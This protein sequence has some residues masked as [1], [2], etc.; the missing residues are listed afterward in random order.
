MEDYR[1]R[2]AKL[3]PEAREKL[4]HRLR[5]MN[6][7]R[8]RDGDRVSVVN[9]DDRPAPAQERVWFL[10]QLEP[11]TPLYNIP[12]GLRLRGRLDVDALERALQ[13]CVARHDALRTN[14]VSVEGMPRVV[15][16]ADM[17]VTLRREDV[18]TTLPAQR[19]K[20]G[21]ECIERVAREPFDLADG[22]PFRAVLVRLAADDHMFLVSVHHSAFDGWSMGIFFADLSSFYRSALGEQD[23]SLSVVPES[24]R[25]YAA[26]EYER[27]ANHNWDRQLAFWRNQLDHELPILELPT[28]RPR[29]AEHSITGAHEHVTVPD[30]TVEQLR[31]LGRDEGCTLFMVTAAIFAVFLCRYGG[32]DE[33]VIGVPVAGRNSGA[34]E[35][36][37]GFFV[38]DLPLRLDMSGELTFRE[39]V[40]RVRDVTLEAYDNQDLPFDRLVAELQPERQ[41]ARTPFFQVMLAFQ[42]TDRTLP[43]LPGISVETIRVSTGTTKFELSTSVVEVSGGLEWRVEY[44]TQL[45]DP[46]T[47]QR[48]LRDLAA[49]IDHCVDAPDASVHDIFICP[50]DEIEKVVTI[51]NDTD[52]SYPR[53]TRIE[54]FVEACAAATP[55]AV[56]LIY[57]SQTVSYGELDETANRVAASLTKLGVSVRDIVAVAMPRSAEMVGVFIGILKAGCAYMPVDVEYP[58]ERIGL[59]MQAAQTPV[60][61]VA[62]SHIERFKQWGQTLLVAEEA[63]C[64]DGA[65]YTAESLAGVRADDVAAVLFTSGSTGEPKGVCIPHRAIVRLVTN[66]NYVDIC[67]DDVI[68]HA[69]NVSFDAH[70]FEIWGAL[71]NGARV[72]E[73]KR[74]V[75]LSPDVFACAMAEYGITILFLTT[76]LFN[77]LMAEVPSAFS[78]LGCLLFGGE[79]CDPDIVRRAVVDG[80]PKR[81]LH[82]YGPTESTTFTTWHEVHEVPLQAHTVPIGRA[83]SNTRVYVLD[84]RQHPVPVGVHG[85]LYIGGDGLATQYLGDAAM[86]AERFVP[87]PFSAA[88]RLYRTGDVVKWNADGELIF[89]GRVDGQ[90]KIRGFR[91]EPGEVETCLRQHPRVEN[92]AV[93]LH[94]TTADTKHLVAHVVLKDGHMDGA[95]DLRLYAQSRIP[96]YMVPAHIILHSQLPLTRTGKVDRAALAATIPAVASQTERLMLPRDD[97]E[98]RIASIWEDVLGQR[99][100]SVTDSFFD[101]G[102]HSLLAVALLARINDEFAE[103][104]PLSMLFKSP[105]IAEFAD[106][107]RSEAERRMATLVP[108]R[109]HGD[110]PPLFCLHEIMGEV[111]LYRNLLPSIAEER[112]VYGLQPVGIDGADEPLRDIH[113]IAAGYVEEIVNAFPGGPYHLIGFSSGGSVAYEM[114]LQLSGAGHEVGMLAI[115]DH[116]AQNTGFRNRWNVLRPRCL[117]HFAGEMCYRLSKA[118][119]DDRPPELRDVDSPFRSIMRLI[120][121]NEGNICVGDPLEALFRNG[122]LPEH[123]PMAQKRVALAHWEGLRRYQPGVYAGD[124]LLFK[125]RVFALRSSHDPLMGWRGVVTGQISTVTLACSH[126]NYIREPNATHVGKAI[127]AYMREW[128]RDH[129]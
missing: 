45:Y 106:E 52:T 87:S 8:N 64:G 1:E 32:Q 50:D 68:G 93:V 95:G 83:I 25:T 10:E 101:I 22:P 36:V 57:G 43:D 97:L 51:W 65:D 17:P 78:G 42:N 35:D 28:D 128:E 18:S 73:L 122:Q 79:H 56:A 46:T 70:L 103:E 117:W 33:V 11:G 80:Q 38:N 108:L 49:T 12:I 109:D 53:E 23:A 30:A 9:A 13:Q 34:F 74:D 85:E 72:V 84:S 96:E 86:T 7:S 90:V 99:D 69:A 110:M 40:R 127:D 61:I 77:M 100:I 129:V 60:A 121:C 94:G 98:R 107:M 37:I 81:L 91:V 118:V 54:Q 66:T 82:V 14:I 124:M 88:E 102:G 39:F 21:I 4:E 112:P 76:S 55:D 67:C 47:I 15:V 71:I 41:L 63:V 29:G 115:A 58:D 111:M 24:Y 62:S 16:H 123:I 44:N 92:V 105:T 59:M 27:S 2:L 114:A 31:A 89:I 6:G 48:F 104:L 3:S 5:K 119:H 19:E 113:E 20:R 126:M 125:P 116:P 120:G 75:I 26:M